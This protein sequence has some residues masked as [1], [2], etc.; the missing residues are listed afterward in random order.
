MLGLASFVIA[1]LTLLISV[2]SFIL[3]NE[4]NKPLRYGLG[5]LFILLTLLFLFVGVFS[6]IGSATPKSLDAP[7]ETIQPSINA[8]LPSRPSGVSLKTGGRF[9]PPP[10]WVWICTGDF[11]VTRSDGATTS[12][13]DQL[14]KTSAI[15]VMEQDS[16]VSLTAPFGGD[17]QPYSQ[18]ER[19][20]AISA[21]ISMMLS[22]PNQC[23]S[24]CLS[25]TIYELDGNGNIKN[26]YAQP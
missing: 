2:M 13:Y 18:S 7:T 24:G 22:D 8:P 17:C 20:A 26:T 6:W 10:N 12:L 19:Q 3:G 5:T 21:T 16:K 23:V 4:S 14:P 9:S 1:A 11:S 15:V 25:I